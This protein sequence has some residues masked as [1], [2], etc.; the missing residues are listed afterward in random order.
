M[1]CNFLLKRMWQLHRYYNKPLTVQTFES[2]V[3]PTSEIQSRWYL[4]PTGVVII[5][6]RTTG[7]IT[8]ESIHPTLLYV[9]F[10][11]SQPKDCDIMCSHAVRGYWSTGV[12]ICSREPA[13]QLGEGILS[14]C[15]LYPILLTPTTVTYVLTGCLQALTD[16]VCW[17]GPG[18]GKTAM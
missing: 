7:S 3:P 2:T 8:E 9:R 11:K 1:V 5:D 18:C 4:H 13:S 6:I 15:D 14:Y 17:A 16:P 10:E 12:E